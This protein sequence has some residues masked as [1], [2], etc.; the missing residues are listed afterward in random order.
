MVVEILPTLQTKQLLALPAGLGLIVLGSYLN[1]G[2]TSDTRHYRVHS[3]DGIYSA[4][5]SDG[6]ITELSSEYTIKRERKG[7][8]LCVREKDKTIRVQ[9]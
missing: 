7:D 3:P 5:P 1:V 9:P 4:V 8:V 2:Y 6:V